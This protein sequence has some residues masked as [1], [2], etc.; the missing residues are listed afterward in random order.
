MDEIEEGTVKWFASNGQ[1]FGYIDR[2]NGGQVYV[3]YKNIKPEM[4]RKVNFMS[5]LKDDRVIYKIGLGYNNV[6]TQA[7]EVEIT[8]YGNIDQP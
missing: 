4:Q 1:S 5:L 8:S 2:D 6:G 3:H 7:L